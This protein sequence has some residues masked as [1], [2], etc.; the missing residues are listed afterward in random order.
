MPCHVFA[1]SKTA[2]PVLA[3]LFLL[4]A[5]ACTPPQKMARHDVTKWR[6]TTF[7]TKHKAISAIVAIDDLP[8]RIEGDGVIVDIVPDTLPPLPS[9]AKPARRY[10][11]KATV[12]SDT[13]SVRIP[14]RTITEERIIVKKEMPNWAWWYRIASALSLFVCAALVIQWLKKL[15]K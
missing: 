12:M 2:L 1:M 14:Q 9:V 15:L 10:K 6:D 4:Q 5:T 11:V 3:S 7:A 13:F 8:V